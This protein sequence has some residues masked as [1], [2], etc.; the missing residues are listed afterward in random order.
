MK[1]I[2]LEFESPPTLMHPRSAPDSSKGIPAH[3]VATLE[4]EVQSLLSKRAIEHASPRV[5]FYARIFLVLK[6]NGKLRPVFNMKLLNRF[7]KAR[8]FHMATLKMV[9]AAIRH[10]DFAVS[11]DLSDAHFHVN[12]APEHRCFLCFKFKGKIFQFKAMSFGLS[13]A[14]RL[15]T[16]LMRVISWYCHQKG[17]CIIFY[18]DDTV[19]LARSRTQAIE[20]RNAVMSLLRKLG[21]LIN[22]EKSDLAPTRQFTFLG[23]LW[24]SVMH[25]VTL[26][27]EKCSK[28]HCGAQRLLRSHSV[29]CRT[30]QK[31]LGLTNFAAFAVPRARLHSRSLQC[32]F[33]H[34]YKSPIH[35]SRICP[36]SETTLLDLRWW[37]DLPIYSKPLSP[38]LPSL[39]IATDASRTGR[40]ASWG[41]HQLAGTW[42]SR[43][44]DHINVLELRAVFIALQQWAPRFRGHTVAIHCDNRMAM[45]CIL[46]EG[47]DLFPVSHDMDTPPSHSSRPLAHSFM[48]SLSAGNG[49]SGGRCVILWEES[50]GIDDS[51]IPVPNA[52][53]ELGSAPN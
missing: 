7:I 41:E 40:G 4:V 26:T 3:K 32:D 5:G 20:H 34:V 46:K 8:G 47:G 12:V 2:H 9:A 50:G 24:D 43:E 23:L 15:F 10:N 6:K 13:S 17:I 33:S 14:P 25:S 19:I 52:L 48:P 35:A 37:L 29:T 30:V 38:P 45:S 27:E 31:F 36:L 16:K 42:D 22:L 21:F 1:G 49:Q 28:L 51:P 44:S 39:A 53:P 11:L 18:L